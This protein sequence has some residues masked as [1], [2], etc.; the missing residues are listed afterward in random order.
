MRNRTE[1]ST[2]RKSSRWVLQ[3][4]YRSNRV[5]EIAPENWR[6]W[7][8][9]PVQVIVTTLHLVGEAEIQLR[10]HSLH[11]VL[12]ELKSSDSVQSLRW[13]FKVDSRN[14]H[15]LRSLGNSQL[16]LEFLRTM[17]PTPAG[18]S[19]SSRVKSFGSLEPNSSE[20]LN[21]SGWCGFLT[22][23]LQFLQRRDAHRWQVS[24]FLSEQPTHK[25][26]WGRLFIAAEQSHVK[27]HKCPS[28]KR[29]LC[30][31]FGPLAGSVPATPHVTRGTVRILSLSLSSGK[32]HSQFPDSS[33][34]D[35]FLSVL[36]N[37]VSDTRG[38]ELLL[39][40]ISLGFSSGFPIE[41]FLRTSELIFLNPSNSAVF[42]YDS[43]NIKA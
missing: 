30:P 14:L 9:R 11:P 39:Q 2:S 36:K 18:R 43:R 5:E 23:V 20:L 22:W 41:Q 6:H 21:Y 26:G 19:Q 28:A 8:G 7:F 12:L 17:T 3:C 24:N 1:G 16:H 15:R 34:E 4:K 42:S 25:W 31:P 10:R 37:N 35:R 40:E 38:T 33:T 27:W 13:V 29:Q 32:L